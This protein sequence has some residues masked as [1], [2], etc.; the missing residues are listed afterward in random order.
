MVA[1]FL[2]TGTK[3]QN[4]TY[5]GVMGM[6]QRKEVDLYLRGDSVYREPENWMARSVPV[7]MEQ[8]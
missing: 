3:L 5:T 2:E 1:G 4:K 8:V 6:L 7:H